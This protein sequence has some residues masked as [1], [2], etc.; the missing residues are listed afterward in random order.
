MRCY[1]EA[2]P[3]IYDRV[4]Q[5][6]PGVTGLATLRFH[7]HE[8]RLLAPCRTPEETE[9]VYRRRCIPRKARLDLIYQARRT[10]WMDILLVIQTARK[11]F[12]RVPRRNPFFTG[13]RVVARKGQARRLAAARADARKAA[14]RKAAPHPA[15]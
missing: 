9:A 1:V 15:E 6:R 3:E 7:E 14:M 13:P 10:L 8:E 2:Y 4:L 12:W 5:S 11:P